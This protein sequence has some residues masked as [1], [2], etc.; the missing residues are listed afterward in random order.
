MMEQLTAGMHMNVAGPD[1]QQ[2]G[3]SEG[4]L[5]QHAVQRCSCPSSA[6]SSCLLAC[7]VGPCVRLDAQT[8]GVSRSV[9]KRQVPRCLGV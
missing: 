1:S 9:C 8:C 7:A 6:R 3:A 4:V 2:L 5:V